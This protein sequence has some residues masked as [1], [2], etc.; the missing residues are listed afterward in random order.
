MRF[1]FLIYFTIILIS[2][3]GIRNRNNQTCFN[4]Q[5]ELIMSGCRGRLIEVKRIDNKCI[6]DNLSIVRWNNGYISHGIIMNGMP[7]G[8]WSTFDKKL[9]LRKEVF[10]G[11][12]DFLLQLIEYD[13]DGNVVNKSTSSVPF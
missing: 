12:G 10:F 2:S 1:C 11:D 9:R 5:N 13:K 8:L 6:Q 4:F 7:V 3:C